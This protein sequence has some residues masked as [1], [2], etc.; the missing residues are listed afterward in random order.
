MAVPMLVE[1]ETPGAMIED[2]TDAHILPRFDAL[3]E[4][5][6]ALSNAATEECIYRNPDDVLREVFR[7]FFTGR[8]FTEKSRLGRPLGRFDKPRPT[9]TEARRSG[10][11]AHHVILSLT[12]LWDQCAQGDVVDLAELPADMIRNFIRH[13]AVDRDGC[14]A[15]G[16]Q[17]QGDGPVEA[18]VSCISMTHSRSACRGSIPERCIRGRRLTG[19]VCCDQWLRSDAW[20]D[21]SET[22][23]RNPDHYVMGQP[24]GLNLTS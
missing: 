3:A 15:F 4:L 2:I 16:M 14:A 6:E 19:G 18:L 12:A 8:Q 23:A 24:S 9:R 22:P 20:F 13:L 7:S 5:A 17:S 1:A 10:R 11:S 21:Q